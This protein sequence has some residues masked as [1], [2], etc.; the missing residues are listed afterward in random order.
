M[1]ERLF[2]EVVEPRITIR[3]KPYVPTVQIRLVMDTSGSMFGRVA[4]AVGNEEIAYRIAW[5]VVATI[6]YSVL[7]RGVRVEG[8]LAFFSDKEEG[9]TCGEDYAGRCLTLSE[10][11]QM[12]TKVGVDYLF[13]KGTTIA[14]A[15]RLFR[16]TVEI[17]T[18]SGGTN[19][20]P[21]MSFLCKKY[22]R[23]LFTAVVTD[24][25]ILGRV[26][27]C[28]SPTYVYVVPGGNLNVPCDKP[29]KCKVVQIGF[30]AS[31]PR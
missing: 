3:R 18:T 24:G 25:E 2:L 5:N 10:Y 14:I 21:L 12:P 13:L 8:E 20:E 26:V 22:W 16:E 6:L 17:A 4:E 27:T 19:P 28:D 15:S 30:K 31:S 11:L 29:E 23:P 7:R 9:F 1:D